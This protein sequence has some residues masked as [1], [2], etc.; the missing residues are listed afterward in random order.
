MAALPGGSFVGERRVIQATCDILALVG[1]DHKNRY[2]NDSGNDRYSWSDNDICNGKHSWYDGCDVDN[3]KHSW[4]HYD[5][6]S[7]LVIH[8]RDIIYVVGKLAW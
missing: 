6:D 1:H 4:W 7:D 8:G 2:D 5:R 3:G